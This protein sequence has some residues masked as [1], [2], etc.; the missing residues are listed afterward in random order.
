MSAE[1]EWALRGVE[2]AVSTPSRWV[3]DAPSRSR[4]SD[5]DLHGVGHEAS[6]VT[7]SGLVGVDNPG[8]LERTANFTR[9]YVDGWCAG[10]SYGSAWGL[11][12]GP[13]GR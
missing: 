9:P 4:T 1:A 13:R 7:H 8:I 6:G 2:A 12:G 11:P 10:W 3:T 5:G